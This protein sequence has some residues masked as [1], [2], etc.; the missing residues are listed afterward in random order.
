MS[1]IL[2]IFHRDGRPVDAGVL[3]HMAET[4]AEAGPDGLEIWADGEIGLAVASF[5]TVPE[6]IGEPAPLVDGD[7]AIAFDGRIDNREELRRACAARGLRVADSA[8]DAAH[9]LAAYRLWGD[10][11]ASKL[12]GEHAFVLWDSQA[13]RVLGVRD[14]MAV[15]SL[16]W[17]SEG[18]TL[19]ACSHFA[20]ILAHPDVRARPNEGAVAEWLC[21]M[22]TSND[23]SLWD[24]VFSVPGGGQLSASREQRA[25]VGRY[26]R[27]QDEIG[28]RRIRSADEAREMVVELTTEAVRCRM[29]AVG[30]PLVELSGG[31]DSSTVAVV[32][33]DLHAAGAVQDFDLFAALYPGL[34]CD[35]TPWIEAMEH[36]LGRTAVKQAQTAVDPA[37]NEATTRTLRHPYARDA[38]RNIPISPER[39]VGLTG[40]AGNEILGGMFYDLASLLNP[41][42]SREILR[43]RPLRYLVHETVRPFIRPLLPPRIRAVRLPE[44]PPWVSPALL[45]RVSFADRVA[46][47]EPLV[48]RG[49]LHA[50]NLAG[51]LDSSTF[52]LQ[53][54]DGELE[55][56]RYLEYRHPLLDVRLVRLALTLPS[57]ITGTLDTDRRRLHDAAFGPRLPVMVRRRRVGADFTPFVT[58]GLLAL[59]AHHRGCPR[60]VAEGWL[61]ASQVERL[62]DFDH[63]AAHEWQ[64]LMAYSV[65]AWHAT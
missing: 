36:H 4:M 33:H 61:L 3:Q 48:S 47:R 44:P 29:R 63:T 12:I 35:E 41:R 53:D 32:A 11:V 21:D 16:R 1:G 26:W 10:R 43:R 8:G 59:R 19:I 51:A 28:Q 20:P 14:H 31:W 64:A 34:S 25:R 56:G 54:L 9:V 22:V 55:R 27:P 49:G 40:H 15:R 57:R 50:R 24:G 65:H 58:A 38:I 7:L 60:L 37:V 42:R 6:Q 2:A 45:E 52:Q 62:D 39:R 23:E 17:W 13:R 5:H 46:R 30:R 18:R